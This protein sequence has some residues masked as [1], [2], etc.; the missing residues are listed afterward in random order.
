M[1]KVSKPKPGK[2][3]N[4][5]KLILTTALALA[6]CVSVSLRAGTFTNSFNDPNQTAGFTLN[7]GGVYPAI[8]TDPIS[9]NGYLALTTA[10]PSENG[11]IVLDPLDPLGTV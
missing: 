5:R 8:V 7:P 4:M 1:F 3:D 6:A 2:D 10:V 11:T 9:Q